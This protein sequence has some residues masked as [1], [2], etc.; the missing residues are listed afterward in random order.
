MSLNFWEEVLAVLGEAAGGRGGNVWVCEELRS[1]DA[2]YKSCSVQ[3]QS[4]A[5]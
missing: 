5:H 1:E 4:L 2:P 3:I